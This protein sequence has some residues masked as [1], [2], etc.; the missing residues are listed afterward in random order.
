MGA[1]SIQRSGLTVFEGACGY[2]NAEWQ[3]PNTVATKF[4]IASIG[5]QFTA[6][7]ALLLK[8]EGKVA[9]ADPVN[10]YVDGL[11]VPWRT[12]TIHQLLTHT[13]G[14]PSKPENRS[15]LEARRRDAL[16]TTP[17]E[18]LDAV[19]V[20]P[21][22]FP[23]G[24]KLAYNNTGYILLGMVIE[25][26]SGMSYPRFIQERVFTPLKMTESGFDDAKRVLPKRA[27]GYIL[28]GHEIENAESVHAT[29]AWS[30]GGFYSTVRDLLTWSASLAQGKL[31]DADSTAR[32]FQTYPETQL[33]GMHYGYGVVLAEKFG[34][35]LHYHGGGI[36]GF[37]SVLQRY[38]KSEL[39]VAVISNLDGG[40][41]AWDV[42]DGLAKLLLKK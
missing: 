21:L 23:H 16:P 13:S 15:E 9:L 29:V 34:E 4:R 36:T 30:A 32:M 40:T 35:S 28:R 14:I 38:P 1:V 25:K 11:P 3:V 10:R 31:L 20:V 41:A 39:V 6:V 2:A 26:A 24:T 22:Q 8:Q 17:R 18:L 27:V 37:T 33:Q 19:Q 12:A 7:A 5:K 42:A